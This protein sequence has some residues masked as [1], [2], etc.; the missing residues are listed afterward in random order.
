MPVEK[1]LQLRS[2]WRA[3]DIEVGAVRAQRLTLGSGCL[4]TLL[5]GLT[6]EKRP[7]GCYGLQNTSLSLGIKIV[8]MA[9]ILSASQ[10]IPDQAQQTGSRGMLTASKQ[11]KIGEWP[12]GSK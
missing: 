12:E 1:C 6:K 4:L 9:T 3:K 8:Y 10:A 7:Y 5:S 11:P 2:L